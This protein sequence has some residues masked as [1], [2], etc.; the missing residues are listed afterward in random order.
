MDHGVAAA[1]A[2]LEQLR[3]S[4]ST[5]IWAGLKT[6]M[7]SLRSSSATATSGGGNPPGAPHQDRKAVVMLLTD[8]CPNI[9]PPAGH[10]QELQNYR[11]ATDFSVQINTFGFGYNLDSKLLH[12]LAVAGAGTYAFIPDAKIVGTTFVDSVANV[13]STL[14][15]SATL[16]LT[17]KNGAAFSGVAG[18]STC[19]GGNESSNED[20]GTVVDLG[21]LSHGQTRYVSVPMH[22]PALGEPAVT[23]TTVPYLEAV[24]QVGGH[25]GTTS[26][27]VS[28]AQRAAAPEMLAGHLTAK[29]ATIGQQAISTAEAGKGQSA[30]DTMQVFAAEVSR[31]ATA[32]ATAEGGGGGSWDQQTADSRVL[33]LH[34][35]VSGRMSKA[36]M[37]Q[38]R[39]NRWGKHY[40]RALVRAHQ[41]NLCTNF[42]DAGLQVN[43]G[44]LFRSLRATGDE[45]FVNLP[46][47][48]P[49]R[50]RGGSSSSR[51][52]NPT[53]AL[54]T[55]T[56]AAA[57]AAART[58][59][60]A[61]AVDMSSYYCGSGGGCF[62]PTS[63]VQVQ[64]Q[65]RVPGA[66]PSTSS[67]APVFRR[68][69]VSAVKRGDMVQT[70]AGLAT[71][72]CVARVA[73]NPAKRL[74]RLPGGLTITGG[75]PVRRRGV[76]C[77]PR[78]QTDAKDAEG[79]GTVYTFVLD[80]CVLAGGGGGGGGGDGGGDG[81]VLLVDGTACVT[82][83]HGIADGVAKHAF[84]GTGN[85]VEALAALPGY[86]DGLVD[87]GG[88]V[89][90]AGPLGEVVGLRAGAAQRAV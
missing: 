34:K 26:I 22:I 54:G 4:G 85:A 38:A 87:V 44:D 46:A 42:M 72:A 80:E 41:L 75:H 3:P 20:W 73:R 23:A 62:G 82:W 56:V 63:T 59:A 70:A 55:T 13:L 37:G 31:A 66:A 9:C 25:G 16:H 89:R 40:L 32:A 90:R 84:F 27:Q 11:D 21:P 88:F 15:H 48:M 74:V 24:L 58:P 33:A 50:A 39:F 19:Y 10:L 86:A 17:E 49:S 6:G 35:D 69:L 12:G 65:E 79:S 77:L 18:G 45:A 14:T 64:V 29:A 36:L 52:V 47:P 7:D 83:G 53:W 28:G 61:P 78:D 51:T 2:A 1:T 30:V 60:P 43:G 5:N 81:R 8:G 67:A 76:W 68:V 71:V 57:A